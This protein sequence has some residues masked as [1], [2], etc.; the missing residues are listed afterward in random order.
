MS[1]IETKTLQWPYKFQV[2]PVESS[3]EGNRHNF[4]AILHGAILLLGGILSS[5]GVLGYLRFDVG[6]QQMINL[7]ILPGTFVFYAVNIALC[8]GVLL[9]FPL[10]LYPVIELL[11]VLLFSKGMCHNLFIISI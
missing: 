11:E 1:K 5:F 7:N 10:Q 3:M 8:L 6:V 9:T 2:I 4:N